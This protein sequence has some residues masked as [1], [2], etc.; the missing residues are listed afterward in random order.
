MKNQSPNSGCWLNL[1][2][3]FICSIPMLLP[4]MVN[5]CKIK[6]YKHLYLY[7]WYYCVCQGSA[8]WKGG[9]IQLELVMAFYLLPPCILPSQGIFIIYTIQEFSS[10]LCVVLVTKLE[11]FFY[12]SFHGWCYNSF[13]NIIF[14]YKLSFIFRKNLFSISHLYVNTNTCEWTHYNT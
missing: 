5:W 13:F 8:S 9:G 14:L 10:F 4:A 11:Q 3:F 2:S 12:F 6:T 1:S 7:Q